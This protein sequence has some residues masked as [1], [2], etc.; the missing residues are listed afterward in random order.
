MH[1][2]PPV[3]SDPYAPST[4]WSKQ[5]SLAN[6]L[7]MNTQRVQFLSIP[8]IFAKNPLCEFQWA[9]LNGFRRAEAVCVG[10]VGISNKFEV[11]MFSLP[12]EIFPRNT[13]FVGNLSVGNTVAGTAARPPAGTLRERVPLEPFWKERVPSRYLQRSAAQNFGAPRTRT[14]SGGLCCRHSV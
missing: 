14:R 9:L 12:A 6:K 7:E 10:A 8:C 1:L 13:D 5:T 2:L 3:K 11:P 4:S